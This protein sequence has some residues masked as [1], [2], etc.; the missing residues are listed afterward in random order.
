MRGETREDA[1]VGD[2]RRDLLWYQLLMLRVDDDSAEMI[3][4]LANSFCKCVRLLVLYLL[5]L[6]RWLALLGEN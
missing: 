5:C 2:G 4:P 6:K 3:N 1:F